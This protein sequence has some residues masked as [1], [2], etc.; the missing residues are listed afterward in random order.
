MKQMKPNYNI[1]Q[2]SLE[3][4]TSYEPKK[5]NTAWF[6]NELVENLEIS[7]P[8]LFGR[9]REYSLSMMLK[10]VLF[11]YTRSVFSSRKIEQLAEES[12]P[13]RW[14]TQES[15]PTYRTIAR[16]RESNDLE[17]LINKGLDHLTAYLRK[18]QLIDDALFIDGTKILAD[19]NKYSFVWK[20]NTIR[21]DQMNREKISVLLVDLKEAHQA[22]YIPEGSN[23]TLEF[24][25]EIITRL[26]L[27]LEDLEKE[28]EETNK[29]SPNPWKQERRYLKS[30]TRK[31]NERRN[32]MVEHQVQSSTY[33]IRNSYSKTDQDATFMRVK[34]D[35]MMNGQLKPAYNLQIATCNQFI[36]GY[37][38]YQNPT[39]TRTLIP[40]LER[41]KLKEQSPKYIVADAGYGSESN[42]RYLEDMLPEHTALIPYST[43]LKEKSKK[44]KTD[45]KKI[46]NWDYFASDDFYIDPLGVR[47]SFNTYR[48]RKDKNGFVR[49]LKEYKAEKYN[50]KQEL[51]SQSL[52]KSGR[53][54]LIQIN[55]ELEYFKAKQKMLLSSKET[56]S[57]Y[58]RRKIDVET[59]FGR[60]KASL[61]FNRFMLRGIDKVRK[62]TG[63]LIMA[64]NMHKLAV[65][66]R[67]E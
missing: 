62:E 5:Q 32:K 40:L 33:G 44:W 27:R 16:F 18:E 60:M 38:I 2:M 19:A 8:Y 30:Q 36:L 48:E 31:L 39:D 65:R 57:I 7:E 1:N 63:I 37:D 29:I 24:L 20:K 41:M 43:M 12:L 59:V 42:Y 45:E 52:T 53:V 26:E 66:S 50:A 34:E 58:A 10:L 6:I 49:Y 17:M 56:A 3:L 9:P 14:L 11:A 25:D 67:K 64:L 13:A 51:V 28:V 54:R 46:M 21:F 15:Q 22:S 61:G 47:F 55:P 23:L 35:P 4:S